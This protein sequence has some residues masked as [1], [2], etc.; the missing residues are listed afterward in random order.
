MFHASVLGRYEAIKA[1]EAWAE[2]QPELMA[3]AEGELKGMDLVCHCWPRRCHG[4]YLYK[5]ANGYPPTIS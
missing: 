4:E 3:R 1:Y 5:R 2:D